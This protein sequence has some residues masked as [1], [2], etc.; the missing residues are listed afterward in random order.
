[1]KRKEITV[2]VFRNRENACSI[3]LNNIRFSEN[4]FAVMEKIIKKFANGEELF[5]GFY[6]TDGINLTSEEF[7]NYKAEIS[8][9]FKTHG[10]MKRL[11]D[12]LSIAR[13]RADNDFWKIFPRI[14]DCYL[15]TVLFNPNLN[16]SLF[17]QLHSEYMER[18]NDD[19]IINNYTQFLFCY[20]DSGDFSVSF[21]P[22]KYAENAVLRAIDEIAVC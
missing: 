10:E 3:V 11:D 22:N 19:Y 14:C 15:N 5:L 20:F 6:R 12:Y 9:F 17:E 2:N 13:T 4:G 18:R 8:D 1:M 21:D 16:W 7:E